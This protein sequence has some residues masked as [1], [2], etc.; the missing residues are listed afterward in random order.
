MRRGRLSA[1]GS[2]HSVIAIVAGSTREIRLPPNSQMIGAPL[3]SN[4]MPY[5]F[6]RGCGYGTTLISPL[7]GSRRPTMFA[8]CAL[9]QSVP[10]RSNK[11]VCGSRTPSG[12]L[13]SVTSPV[14]G[15]SRPMYPFEFAVNQIRPSLSAVRPCGPD[16]GVF[17]GYSLIAPVFGSTRP[18]VLANMPVYQ[19]APS[20][21]ASGSCGREPSVGRFHSLND[22]FAAP[23]INTGLGRGCS[24]K[25]F[26][27]YSTIV[28]L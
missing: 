18:S 15:S 7:F 4:T 16:C 21:V 11:G 24:G 13:N 27:R 6:E 19:M 5:G 8:F 14:A 3:E 26:V 10:L 9:N 28:S 17:N 22:T 25:F 12:S 2:V 23:A 1:F 20:G